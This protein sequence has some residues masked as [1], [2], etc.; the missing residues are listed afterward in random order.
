MSN[1]FVAGRPAPRL[2]GRPSRAGRDD[3]SAIGRPGAGRLG[4][5]AS[6][7]ILEGLSE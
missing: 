1:P 7:A 6:I 2:R 5:S 4:V 3:Q